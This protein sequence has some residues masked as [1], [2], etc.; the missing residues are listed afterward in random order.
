MMR[1]TPA[2]GDVA[3]ARAHP[4]IPGLG[5]LLNPERL[6]GFTAP[7]GE[8]SRWE[9]LRLKPGVSLTVALRTPSG[10]RLLLRAMSPEVW[11]SKAGKDIRAGQRYARRLARAGRRGDPGQRVDHAL[12]VLVQPAA[13]DRHLRPLDRWLPDTGLQVTCPAPR[14]SASR[15]DAPVREQYSEGGRGT[16]HTLSYNPARRF[17]GCW[18]EMRDPA[19]AWVVRAHARGAVEVAPFVPGRE[20]R[21]GDGAVPIAELAR[22]R[23]GTAS[24]GAPGSG[25]L[26]PDPVRTARAAARWMAA[27]DVLGHEWSPRLLDVCAR[28]EAPLRDVPRVPSHGDFSTDQVVVAPDGGMTVLDWDRAGWWPGGWDDASWTVTEALAGRSPGDA[29]LT[30]PV[31]A[32]VAV[33][34]A[35]EPFRRGAHAWADQTEFLVSLAE[36]AIAEGRGWA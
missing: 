35:P 31:A 10:V 11:D 33:A 7:W 12:A 19:R 23:L 25:G 20:W 14:D 2:P 4:Q 9:R 32:A 8:I 34:R 36:R 30:G 13:A 17:V 16:T 21:P 22:E 1:R 5:V 27:V 15:D 26:E 3:V 18:R 24:A 6:A 29:H 28:L